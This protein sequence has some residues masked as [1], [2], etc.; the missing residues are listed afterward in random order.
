MIPPSSFI[1][2]EVTTLPSKLIGKVVATGSGITGP[3]TCCI[4]SKRKVELAVP[5][6]MVPKSKK[7]FSLL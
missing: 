6:P 7:K 1:K 5:S 2:S 3:T 4:S